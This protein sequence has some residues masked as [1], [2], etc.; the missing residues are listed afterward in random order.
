MAH[1]LFFLTAVK[2]GSADVAAVKHIEYTVVV[3]FIEHSALNGLPQ[4]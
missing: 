4:Y 1:T 2:E 3:S